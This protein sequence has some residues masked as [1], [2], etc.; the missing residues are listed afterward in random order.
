MITLDLTSQLKPEVTTTLLSLQGLTPHGAFSVCVR[1]GVA[2]G[3]GVIEG[4][5]DTHTSQATEGS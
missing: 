4:V 2:G 1:A 5:G 3:G